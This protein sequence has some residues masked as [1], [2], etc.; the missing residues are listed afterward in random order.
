MKIIEKI[1]ANGHGSL[2]P[3]YVA[4]HETANPGATA[5]EHVSF[6]SNNPTYA[7]HYVG[8]WTENIYHT[9][10]DN[11]LCYQVGNGNAKVI[12]I[13]LCHAKTQAD[14]NKVWKVGVEW[15]TWMLKKKGWGVDRLI[16]HD[17]A[18]RWWGGTDHTDPIGYF[19]KFGKTWDQFKAEVAAALK[20]TT[21]PATPAQ[22][23]NATY[24]VQVGAY[25][26]KANATTQANKLK[27]AG[28]DAV[29]VQVDKLYK[30]QVGAYSAKAN[31][32]AM[33]A[34]LKKAGYTAVIVGGAAAKPAT[35]AAP[36]NPYPEP[37]NQYV[38]IGTSG[39]G[40][41]WVQWELNR[42]GYN[43]VVDGIIGPQ[44][45]AAIRAFQ[46]KK[47]LVADGIVGPATRAALKK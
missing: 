17:D 31:A 25:S 46:S 8:D 1:V 43:L 44:S 32:D 28:F 42:H 6:W 9:V 45:G 27:K 38:Q 24:K 36:K 7:V 41:K 10:P 20:G 30:V 19:K 5:L 3:S 14:F 18:R 4:I 11:R 35:P 23:S 22:P 2:N 40:A 26:K 12:G 16:S 15:A 21:A 13:E 33:V 34:K 29:V 39:N 37:T 47:G